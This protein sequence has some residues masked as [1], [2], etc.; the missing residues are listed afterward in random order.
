MDRHKRKKV[1]GWLAKQAKKSNFAALGCGLLVAF[2]P[3]PLELWLR[4]HYPSVSPETF[5]YFVT[6]YLIS[7][8]IVYILSM[9]IKYLRKKISPPRRNPA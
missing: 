3:E 4:E 2:R 5:A 9:P 8:A 1:V 7:A 6:M